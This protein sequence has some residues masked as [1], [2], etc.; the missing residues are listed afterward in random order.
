[1]IALRLETDQ[2][3]KAKEAIEHSQKATEL[4]RLSLEVHKAEGRGE[5]DEETAIESAVRLNQQALAESDQAI[6]LMREQLGQSE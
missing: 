2:K 3:E 4:F 6:R 5:I 1:M